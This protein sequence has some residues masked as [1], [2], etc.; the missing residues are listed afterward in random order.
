MLLL[1]SFILSNFVIMKIQVFPIYY[2]NEKRIGVKPLGFDRIFPVS[3]KKIKGSLWSS[4]EHCWHIPY[5]TSAFE[6]LKYLFGSQHILSLNKKPIINKRQRATAKK[7]KWK[8][9]KYKDEIARYQ[10]QLMI[11][12]Y[13]P[14]TRK[15]YISFFTQ[16]LAYFSETDPQLLQKEDIIKYL[17]YKSTRSKWSHSTQN[18]AVNAIK[19]YYEH[20]LGQ[21]RTFYEFRPRKEK[22]LPGVFSEDEVRLLFSMVTNIKHKLILKLIYSSGLRIGECTN[23]LKTDLKID[24]DQIFI[25][26]GKG[27]KDRYTVLSPLLKDDIIFYMEQ[28]QPEYWLIEGQTGG[29][30]SQSSIR[31]IFRKAVAMASLD[32]Y[33]TV[34]TLR[35]SFAT[36]LHERGMDIRIIQQL[37][38]HASSETTDIYTHLTTKVKKKFF[39]PLDFIDIENENAKESEESA[40]DKSPLDEDYKQE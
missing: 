10:D 25:K 37:L 4:K 26:G 5:S 33:S 14:N 20:V 35:H 2:A 30:Y 22:K 34:H 12:R 38:G 31:K 15:V 29:R 8:H 1:C 6:Q 36:H 39:S 32:P 23:L 28:F 40:D 18:Q 16:F 11:K 24:R 13:Q 19:F 21:E 7:I 27:K 9:L 17:I 3:M